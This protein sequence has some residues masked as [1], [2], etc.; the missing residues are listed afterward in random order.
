MKNAASGSDSG[1]NVLCIGDLGWKEERKCDLRYFFHYEGAEFVNLGQN[2]PRHAV[3]RLVSLSE[4][5]KRFLSGQYE[6]VV[7]GSIPTPFLNPRKG[8]LHRWGNY[9]GRML[10]IPSVRE[11]IRGEQMLKLFSPRLVAL[12]L[13]DRPIIDNHRFTAGRLCQL[14]FKRELPQNPANAFLYTTD[15]NED[16]GN[17]P[18]QPFFANFI[19]KLRPIS[20]GVEPSILERGK[21]RAWEKTSDVFFVGRVANRPNRPTGMKQL[22]RLRE[23][24]FR[25]DL[26]QTKV[27]RA[28]FF[29]RCA[30]SLSVWSPEGFGYDCTRT[31]EAA[32]MGSVPILQYPTIQRHAPLVDGKHALYYGVE[33]DEL[34]QTLRH[35]LARPEALREIGRAAQ[36]QVARH[37]TFGQL[38]QYV[39]ETAKA[40]F[41]SA[42]LAPR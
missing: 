42:P 17:I 7:A 31:Y 41:A 34:Y 35:W 1:K 12:D 5:K 4:A 27:N 9:A 37:H 15:K 39:V 18:R 20:I 32:A 19:E 2:R 24:G 3:D 29:E 10:H 25:M 8:F 21:S 11:A 36:E 16:N 30:A 28:D 13:E 6:V 38:A 40:T 14:F 23:E 33:G 22:E 26:P